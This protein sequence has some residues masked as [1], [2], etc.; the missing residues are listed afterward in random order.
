[1]NMCTSTLLEK[2][3]P[4]HTPPSGIPPAW[5]P[6]NQ[7]DNICHGKCMRCILSITEL[8]RHAHVADKWFHCTSV[9]AKWDR[10]A[11]GPVCCVTA[12]ENVCRLS[13]RCYC[14]LHILL[15]HHR[16][17]QMRCYCSISRINNRRFSSHNNPS[18]WTMHSLKSTHS[19][20]T[21]S[22]TDTYRLG[23]SSC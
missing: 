1:M 13:F 8:P 21:L 19:H 22:H 12:F 4:M 6:S 2:I 23:A 18:A 11:I 17:K 14:T 3:K 5:N 10:L 7:W 9:S 16:C 15:L 20:T